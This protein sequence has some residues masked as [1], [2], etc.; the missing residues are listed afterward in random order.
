MSIDATM[1]TLQREAADLRSRLAVIEA[2]I[3]ALRSGVPIESIA[4]DHARPVAPASAW[5]S[6][7]T[8]YPVTT[9]AWRS[10]ASRA[11]V[12]R[13]RP[14]FPVTGSCLR[15]CGRYLPGNPSRRT[16]TK[17]PELRV[18]HLGDEGTKIRRN[19]HGAI[20]HT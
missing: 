14:F 5:P 20:A 8:S 6:S 11:K 1:H 16:E 7:S 13:S 12:A 2:R 10:R 19:G 17:R 3:A 9:R 15:K 18:Q 4:A